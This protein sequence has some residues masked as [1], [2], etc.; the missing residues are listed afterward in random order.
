MLRNDGRYEIFILEA[1]KNEDWFRINFDGSFKFGKRWHEDGSGKEYEPYD[2]F[3]AN[4]KCWQETGEDA[5][6]DVEKAIK[7]YLILM[8]NNPE[9]MFRVVKKTIWQD[10]EIMWCG[11]EKEYK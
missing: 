3:S 11:K 5:T 7:L 9:Y 8:K 2:S 6:Y 1:K 10:S 4:G